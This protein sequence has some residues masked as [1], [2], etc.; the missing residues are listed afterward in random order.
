MTTYLT[1]RIMFVCIQISH[2]TLKKEMTYVHAHA[3]QQ[4]P[5]VL[6]WL[7]IPSTTSSVEDS[8]I[9]HATLAKES[10]NLY[11]FIGL[12]IDSLFLSLLKMIFIPKFSWQESLPFQFPKPEFLKAVSFVVVFSSF[13]QSPFPLLAIFWHPSLAQQLPFLCVFTEN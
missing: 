12:L 8:A 10:R 13:F 1:R 3:Y 2:S 6:K 5:L 9:G 4:L 11:T 7:V